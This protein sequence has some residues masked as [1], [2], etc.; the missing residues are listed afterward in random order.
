MPIQVRLFDLN[1]AKLRMPNFYY[2]FLDAV[3]QE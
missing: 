3:V 1:Y 2:D